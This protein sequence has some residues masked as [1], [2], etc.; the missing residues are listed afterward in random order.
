[1]PEQNTAYKISIRSFS[2]NFI[3]AID[4]TVLHVGLVG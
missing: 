2:L 4:G 1:M 3:A